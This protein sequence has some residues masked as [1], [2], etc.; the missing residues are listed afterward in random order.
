MTN[1]VQSPNR[2]H[3]VI[4]TG[5]SGSGKS[6][7]IRALEDIG[8]F[9]ID[10][11]PIVILE[12]LLI[13]ID[14]NHEMHRIAL[15]IDARERRFLSSFGETLDLIERM[16][17][18][19]DVLF[20][21]ASDEVII[22]RFSETRR[23][24]PLEGE[25]GSITEAI[26]RERAMLAVL[27]ERARWV[28]DSSSLNVHQLKSMVQRAYDPHKTVSMN[29]TALSFGYRLGVPRE[30]DYVFDCR[31]LSNPYF[32]PE[33]R[34]LSGQDTAVKD[35][36]AARPEWTGFVSRLADLI[37][38]ALPLHEAEGKPLLTLA[39]GCTGGRHR[40]V[41]VAEAV[42]ELLRQEEHAVRVVH[43][44]IGPKES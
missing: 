2:V 36:L 38:F 27:R 13:I 22:N 40:S 14:D 43:R 18:P 21:D 33:L 5:L 28:I 37:R 20:L 19:V 11:L 1:G 34:R 9:C 41:A 16:G 17:H 15:G 12:K 23:R 29:V 7:A 42:A 25:S 4:V 39:F 30:A 32:V 10:N 26:A 44:D 6:T 24:H 3:V 8:F 35:F 31:L